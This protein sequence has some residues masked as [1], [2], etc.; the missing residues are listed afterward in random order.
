MEMTRVRLVWMAALSAGLVCGGAAANGGEWCRRLGI[1][2]G[3]GYQS[4][5]VRPA[6]RPFGYD[7]DAGDAVTGGTYRHGAWSWS[8]AEFRSTGQA[9]Y[10]GH[11]RSPQAVV[12]AAPVRSPA[13]RRKFLAKSAERLQRSDRIG[14]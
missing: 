1:G 8:A 12:R 4:G 6:A 14:R 13:P 11:G 3:P 5:L 9:A 7:R 2:H 10:R